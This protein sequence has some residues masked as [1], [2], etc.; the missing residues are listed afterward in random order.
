MKSRQGGT[1]KSTKARNNEF[2]K[3][4]KRAIYF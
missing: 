4:N 3:M 1:K 2:K